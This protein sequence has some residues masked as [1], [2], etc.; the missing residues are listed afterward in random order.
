MDFVTWLQGQATED[1]SS[2]ADNLQGVLAVGKELQYCVQRLEAL[3][4]F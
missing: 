4:Y 3:A 2:E 1:L